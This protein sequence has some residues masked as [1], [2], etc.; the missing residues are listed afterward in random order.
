VSASSSDPGSSR[1]IG[2]QPKADVLL[3]ARRPRTGRDPPDGGVALNERP[4]VVQRALIGHRITADLDP[5]ELAV[6][7]V[8]VAD[9]A[10][11]LF[12][13]EVDLLVELDVLLEAG[14]VKRRV[15]PPRDV[16]PELKIPAS[17]RRASLGAITRI[18]YGSPA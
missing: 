7:E 17:I 15:R 18:P 4:E 16:R 10:K 8:A 2:T 1:R 12:P 6:E 5:H 11:C 13:D 9:L 14:E 3:Q